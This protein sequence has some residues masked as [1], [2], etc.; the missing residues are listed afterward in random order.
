MASA[1][2]EYCGEVE[3]GEHV[4]IGFNDMC[5]AG[6]RVLLGGFTNTP[7]VSIQRHSH[8][9]RIIKDGDSVSWAIE[10]LHFVEA[11]TNKTKVILEKEYIYIYKGKGKKGI[12]LVDY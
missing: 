8:H 11:Q 10:F 1:R 9:S 5:G 7:L 6:A 12:F 2:V 3:I 4:V